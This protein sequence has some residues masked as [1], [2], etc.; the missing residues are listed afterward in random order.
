[1]FN[2]PIGLLEH[3]QR[4]TNNHNFIKTCQKNSQGYAIRRKREACLIAMFDS[5]IKLT[6][7]TQM[8]MY[9]QEQLNSMIGYYSFEI[10]QATKLSDFEE[11]LRHAWV[12]F[13]EIRQQA[14][15]YNP[16]KIACKKSCS[17]CCH[18]TV[19]VHAYEMFPIFDFIQA[20]FPQKDIRSVLKQAEKNHNIMKDLSH[21]ECK[22]TNIRCPLLSSTGECMCYEVRPMACRLH[23]ST[24][25]TL[26]EI[27]HADPRQEISGGF[28]E[29]MHMLH[30]MIMGALSL[31][32]E[33][34]QYDVRKYYLNHAVLE[35]L[36][37]KKL[38]NRWKKKKSIFSS[39]ALTN[40][41]ASIN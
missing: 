22:L 7:N 35:C 6:R 28:I 19:T 33:H 40:E 17:Y 29:D 11:I 15:A 13:E 23:H 41:E 39:T 24:D 25:M 14:T 32:Y 20:K 21:E 30:A 4:G 36:Q 8:N 9:G 37:N 38:I 34:H 1:M 12:R 5:E 10:V 26:C 3:T 2:N 27:Q 18:L 31:A 16:S